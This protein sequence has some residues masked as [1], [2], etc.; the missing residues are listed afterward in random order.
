MVQLQERYILKK[1]NIPYLVLLFGAARGRDWR[2]PWG[3][4][5]TRGHIQVQGGVQ[6]FRVIV[7]NRPIETTS[8]GPPVLHLAVAGGREIVL[9]VLGELVSLH[10]D[11]HV[12]HSR[13]LV[14]NSTRFGEAF[15]ICVGFLLTFDLTTFFTLS[16]FF[17]SNRN[18][19]EDLFF[20]I[21]FS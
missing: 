5:P 9:V 11:D 8:A 17:I 18:L 6:L 19:S 20:R 2:F 12:C 7:L 14:L 10:Q 4:G 1:Q 3:R 16:F 21:K 15:A 13:N